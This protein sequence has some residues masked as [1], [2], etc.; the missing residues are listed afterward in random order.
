MGQIVNI[1]KHVVLECYAESVFLSNRQPILHSLIFKY[2]KSSHLF[3]SSL[4]TP[5][6]YEEP[7]GSFL[8]PLLFS[9]C[10]LP[11]DNIV[12]KY[13]INFQ[14]YADDIELY[15][16]TMS[17]C[18]KDIKDCKTNHFI[19]LNSNSKSRTQLVPIA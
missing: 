14:C 4:L 17:E 19:R 16:S 18:V 6:K 7:Q 15:L 8:D 9:I 10:M 2:F 12:R 3:K 11:L 13:G 5:V 1:I